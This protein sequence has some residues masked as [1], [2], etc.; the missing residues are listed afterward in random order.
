MANKKSDVKAK[1]EFV[2]L[3]KNKGFGGTK[4]RGANPIKPTV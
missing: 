1:K 2:K 3:L 4:G